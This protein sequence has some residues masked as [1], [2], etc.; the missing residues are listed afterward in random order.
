MARIAENAVIQDGV[1]YNPGEE[2][3][4]FLWKV[5]GRSNLIKK[6]YRWQEKRERTTGAVY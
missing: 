2:I 6:E 4:D 1:W 5:S 3:P